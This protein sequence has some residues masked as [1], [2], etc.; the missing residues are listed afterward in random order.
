MVCIT[1][2]WVQPKIGP[3]VPVPCGKCLPCVKRGA[4]QWGFRLMQEAKRSISAQFLTFTY[5]EAHVPFSENKFLTLDPEHLRL[6]MM[7]LRKDN[8]EHKLKYYAVGEYGK[9]FF[10]PHYHMLLFNCAVE[11]VQP[12]WDYGQ[13]HYGDV[14]GAS[15]SYT[16]KYMHKKGRIPMHDR[17]DR[18]PEFARMSKGLGSNYLTPEVVDWHLQKLDRLYTVTEEG[19]KVPLARYY[20]DRIFSDANFENSEQA[21]HLRKVADLHARTRAMNLQ[22]KQLRKLKG[23]PEHNKLMLDLAMKHI[24]QELLNQGGIL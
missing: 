1:P 18:F 20:K 3:K 21:F 12:N 2:Y 13:V 15:I 4:S 6:F 24:Q 14:A 11:T 7:K 17:D 19:Y 8:P 5:D 16:L 23:D 10:R 9:Q 22:V